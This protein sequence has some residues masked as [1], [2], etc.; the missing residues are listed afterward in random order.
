MPLICQ[1]SFQARDAPP[2]TELPWTPILYKQYEV[3]KRE[4]TQFTS[5]KKL[6]TSTSNPHEPDCNNAKAYKTSFNQNRNTAQR[7][8]QVWNQTTR[9]SWPQA[10]HENRGS[11][12]RNKNLRGFLHLERTCLTNITCYTLKCFCKHS[13]QKKHY[14]TCK[15]SLQKNINTD[16]LHKT[17]F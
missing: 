13:L 3:I 5:R 11:S 17:L 2:P 14:K 10:T 1:Y 8:M 4:G 16:L 6:V 9:T 15:H 7:I 12:T